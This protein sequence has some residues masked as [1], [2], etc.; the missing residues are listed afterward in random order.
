MMAPAPSAP[1]LRESAARL[2]HSL[3]TAPN[4]DFRLAVLKRTA[5][6]SD[7]QDGYPTFLKLLIVIAESAEIHAKRIVAATLRNALKR[8]DL[9]VGSLTSWGGSRLWSPGT[10]VPPGALDRGLF[11]DA[12]RRSFGPI[13]YLTAW[14][15]QRTQRGMLDDSVYASAAA[16][17]VGLVNCDDEAAS[18][19]PSRLDNDTRTELEGAFTRA[20]RGRLSALASAWKS[21]RSPEQI[22]AAAVSA[23][24]SDQQQQLP[25]GWLVRDL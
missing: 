22:A 11:G 15:C 13:E 12:P 5:K 8:M 18:L 25:H 21:G 4:D 16:A 2:A 10:A 14:S 23:T 20:T 6:R 24:S 19:Y 3:L 1:A 7:E 17:L 9:P